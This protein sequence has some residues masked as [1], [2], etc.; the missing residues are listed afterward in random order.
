MALVVLGVAAALAPVAARLALVVVVLIAAVA[1]AVAVPVVLV[2]LAVAVVGVVLMVVVTVAVLVTLVVLVVVVAVLVIPVPVFAMV[3]VAMVVIVMA[4]VTMIVVAMAVVTMVVVVPMVVFMAMAVIVVLVVVT[5][6]GMARSARLLAD[7]GLGS[8]RDPAS[9]RRPGRPEASRGGGRWGRGGRDGSGRA[10]RRR[11]GAGASRLS[12]SA[13]CG[14]GRR[15]RRCDDGGHLAPAGRRGWN[16]L[17]AWRLVEEM[18]SGQY[19]GN[20]DPNGEHAENGCGYAR[21]TAPHRCPIGAPAP[22]LN[23]SGEDRSSRL[24][25][26]ALFIDRAFVGAWEIQPSLPSPSPAARDRPLLL[27]MT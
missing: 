2:T 12:A 11:D 5:S 13:R 14:P 7:S 22:S 10:R 18:W 6:A 26:R 15:E 17:L 21:K 9:G 1:P 4:V 24:P 23:L 20:R 3:M 16:C 27:N 25:Q 8:G 19:E